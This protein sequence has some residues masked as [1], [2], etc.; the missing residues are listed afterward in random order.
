MSFAARNFVASRAYT[1][2]QKL[3]ASDI[4]SNKYFGGMP[5]DLASTYVGRSGAIS[6]DGTTIVVGAPWPTNSNGA[7]YVFVKSG[8]TWTEQARLPVVAPTSDDL[9]GF[10][11]ALSDN[12]NTA[13]IGTYELNPPKTKQSGAFVFVRSGTTWTQQAQL[14]SSDIQPGD[15]FGAS[16]ALSGDGN[17]ALIG[18]PDEDTSPRS[19]NGAAYVFTRSGTTW[20]QQTKLLASNYADNDKFGYSVSLS[21]NGTVA[22]IGAPYKTVSFQ[23]NSGS[24]YVFTQTAG[25]WSQQT[26]LN[27]VA[28]PNQHLGSSV[29]LS[30][31]GNQLIIGA[32]DYN[33]IGYAS[34]IAF[35]YENSAGVWSLITDILFSTPPPS[36]S[37][38]LGTSVAISGNGTVIAIG[39]PGRSLTASGSGEILIYVKVGSNWV[40]SQSITPIDG[41][42]STTSQNRF[43]QTVCIARNELTLVGNAPFQNTS[44]YVANGAAYIFVT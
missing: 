1:Q 22:A 40:K 8:S 29:S 17:T 32:P 43:G 27:G 41:G 16:V 10:S 2:V 23:N 31:S 21:E 5:Y 42:F 39:V 38:Y 9:F 11:V 37:L 12:G 15:S 36:E 19:T 34:G 30:S 25:V 4:A 3:L 33:I 7:I 24:V 26:Q 44:P 28:F 13:L 14:L 6:A 20:S 18:A 35:V